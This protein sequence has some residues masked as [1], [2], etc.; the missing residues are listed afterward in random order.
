MQGL[1]FI[2]K[3]T[4]NTF[5][6]FIILILFDLLVIM[7][8]DK[9]Q[10]FTQEDTM[11][12]GCFPW[13]TYKPVA[14]EYVKKDGEEYQS[15]LALKEKEQT[16][17]KLQE[18]QQKFYQEKNDYIKKYNEEYKKL[19]ELKSKE[20]AY[21]KLQEEQAQLEK[22]REEFNKNKDECFKEL[23]NR[24]KELKNKEEEYNKFQEEQKKFDQ[25][26]ANYVKRDDIK[27]NDLSEEEKQK[28][29]EEVFWNSHVDNSDVTWNDLIRNN[30]DIVKGVYLRQIEK[31][32]DIWDYYDKIN[33]LR[34]KT[35]PAG[36]DTI[37]DKEGHEIKENALTEQVITNIKKAFQ[38]NDVQNKAYVDLYDTTKEGDNKLVDGTGYNLSKINDYQVALVLPD[39]LLKTK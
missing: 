1:N 20:E 39:A 28:G 9:A 19:E 5:F 6:F 25:E 2:Y 32:A 30:I 31:F 29:V 33:D 26:K 11:Y 27:F 8:E 36:I 37:R 10:L 3:N 14:E 34:P 23:G 17:N 16:Y 35:K 12:C 7:A 15:L 24:E 13:E 18:E 38:E 21:N 22:D 4:C